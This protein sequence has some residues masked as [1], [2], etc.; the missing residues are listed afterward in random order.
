MSTLWEPVSGKDVIMGRRAVTMGE[1]GKGLR[2]SVVMAWD[3]VAPS[4]S[5][6]RNHASAGD[7][8]ERR[9][10]SGDVA[11]A[12]ASRRASWRGV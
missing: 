12:T 10:V 1:E 7:G 8:S 6:S 11:K 4:L 2:P 9:V 5:A 3:G